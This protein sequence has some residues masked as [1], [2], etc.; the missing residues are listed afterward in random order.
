MSWDQL[1]NVIQLN[2]DEQRAWAD[3]APQACPHDGEPLKTDAD[4]PAMKPLNLE[5]DIERFGAD[6]LGGVGILRVA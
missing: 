6:T 4:V 1:I 2:R 3:A 5:R